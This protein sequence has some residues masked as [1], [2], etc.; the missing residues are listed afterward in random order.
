M[1]SNSKATARPLIPH[2]LAPVLLAMLTLSAVQPTFAVEAPAARAAFRQVEMADVIAAAQ[3]A[4]VKIDVTK[5]VGGIARLN[6]RPL[7]FGDGSPLPDFLRRFGIPEQGNPQRQAEGVGSGFIIDEAGHVVTNNHVID[8]AQTMTVTLHDGRTLPAK[9]IGSDPLTDLALLRIEDARQLPVIEFGDSDSA[10]V[11]DWVVAIGSPFGFGGS[12]TAGI[13]S[14]RGRDIRSGPYD[15]FLQIDA[16]I[17][18]GNSGGPVLDANGKVIGVNTAIFSPTGGNIG[19]GFAIPAAEARRV[20]AELRDHGQVTRG[21]L[22][23]QIQEITADVA[24]ALGLDEAR[25][26]LV[27]VVVDKSPA[28]RAGVRTGDVIVGFGDTAVQTPRDLSRAVARSTPGSKVTLEIRRD[29]REQRLVTVID[30]NA[31]TGLAAA[32]ESGAP[33]AATRLE[34]FGLALGPISPDLRQQMNLDATIQGAMVVGVKDGGSADVSGVRPGDVIVQ[35]NRE[36]TDDAAQAE[37]ALLAA[38]SS[39]RPIVVLIRRGPEQF[40]TTIKVA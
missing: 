13:I 27:A 31:E 1:S 19:I 32:P 8:G 12:V 18:S 21:W 6:G 23:V 30:R 39:E 11:G 37:Q 10:R 14:A 35:V 24:A 29:G 28:A 22:G 4:V 34:S 20:V 7:P 3:P 15:D 38:R 26:A 5:T 25:G 36:V 16:P 33:G 9:L 17:N 40:F 2:R